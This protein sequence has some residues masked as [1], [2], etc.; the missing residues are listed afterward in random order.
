MPGVAFHN[1]RAARGQRRGRVSPHHR[2]CE[3][4]IARREIDHRS[5]RN[6]DAAEIRTHPKGETRIGRIQPHFEIAAVDDDIGKQ[7]QLHGGALQLASQ[8]CFGKTRLGNGD[9]DQF[10][11][12]RREGIRY[13]HERRGPFVR[14]NRRKDG[15]RDRRSARRCLDD[16]GDV[17]WGRSGHCDALLELEAGGKWIRWI[18][19]I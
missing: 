18:Q 7:S 14:G 6:Q 13:C 19:K 17:G 3:G 5:D 10:L 1:D 9:R 12:G 2:E 16:R 4:K 11:G 15:S 8:P